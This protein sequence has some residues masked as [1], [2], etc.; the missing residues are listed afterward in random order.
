MAKTNAP[1]P[2]AGSSQL[3]AFTPKLTRWQIRETR[4]RRKILA[5][6]DLLITQGNKKHR[7]AAQLQQPYTTLWRWRNQVVPLVSPGRKSSFE[8]IEVPP[9]VVNRV[10]RLQL[11]GLG[12]DTAWR[13]VATDRI[14]PPALRDFLLS[15]KT[16]PLS[17]LKA[18]RLT[19]STVKVVSG[20]NFSFIKSNSI[21]RNPKP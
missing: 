2:G 15:A 20:A 21:E 8:K 9:A 16:I 4:R 10:Q 17:F 19:V 6:F 18:S 14:T 11:S 13:R 1:R 3:P 5:E 7:A 12:N